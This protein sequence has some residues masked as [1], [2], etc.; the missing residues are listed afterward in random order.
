QGGEA[1]DQK[2]DTRSLQG[3]VEDI[4]SEKVRAQQVSA[5]M[6]KGCTSQELTVGEGG[7]VAL[8][9]IALIGKQAVDGAPRFVDRDGVSALRR[10]RRAPAHPGQGIE[11]ANRNIREQNG[12]HDRPAAHEL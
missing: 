6:A 4:A 7:G 2:C 11:E 3:L 12:E 10:T 5:R 1:P 8:L 9:A